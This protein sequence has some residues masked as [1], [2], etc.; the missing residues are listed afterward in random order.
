MFTKVFDE[1]FQPNGRGVWV[2]AFAGTTL[3][4]LIV[5]GLSPPLPA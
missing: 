5:P 3:D 2:R 1:I 4:M